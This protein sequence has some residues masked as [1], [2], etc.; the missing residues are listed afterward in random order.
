[1]L[2]N[3]QWDVISKRFLYYYFQKVTVT[4]Q[5]GVLISQNFKSQWLMNKRTSSSSPEY[6]VIYEW[7]KQELCFHD[8]FREK[9]TREK[10][11]LRSCQLILPFLDFSIWPKIPRTAAI[12]SLEVKHVAPSCRNQIPWLSLGRFC[13]ACAIKFCTIAMYCNA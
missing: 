4:V 2:K 9:S 5:C 8:V 1:M 7:F 10:S 13:N 3:P 12:E 6:E 11:V